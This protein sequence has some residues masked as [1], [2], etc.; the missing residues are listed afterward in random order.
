VEATVVTTL[1]P[2]VV[3]TF[4]AAVEPALE[5]AVVATVGPA[6]RSALG[7]AGNAKARAGV[8]TTRSCPRARAGLHPAGRTRVHPA[9]AR[10]GAGAGILASG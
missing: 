2:A 1:L 7:R 3:T 8:Q 9:C 6:I 5:S 10:S 4:V